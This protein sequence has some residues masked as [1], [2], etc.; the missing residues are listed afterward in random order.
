MR[1]FSRTALLIYLMIHVQSSLYGTSTASK[2][3]LF[4]YLTSLIVEKR[5]VEEE[6]IQAAENIIS[7]VCARCGVASSMGKRTSLEDFYCMSE[8][9]FGV[10]DGHQ[11]QEVAKLT[12]Q[13]LHKKITSHAQYETSPATAIKN[14][15]HSF[16]KE[17]ATQ[18]FARGQSA[19]A[20][21]ALLKKNQLY[22][23]GLG[24]ARTL[25]VTSD[26]AWC[27]VD[28]DIQQRVLKPSGKAEPDIHEIIITPQH[29]FAII[30]TQSIWKHVSNELAILT[31]QDGLKI[32][33]S[34][35]AAASML[36]QTAINHQCED[37]MTAMIIDLKPNIRSSTPTLIPHMVEAHESLLP[38][39]K[40]KSAVEKSKEHEMSLEFKKRLPE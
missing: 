2:L 16:Q 37:N 1:Q 8:P 14:S 27:S 24:D 29:K 30:A 3:S 32:H 23:A 10:Y 26:Y 38:L 28:H 18:Q 5:R 39:Q 22:V 34:L 11:G 9:F 12:A 13:S 36:V 35:E 33:K 6:K 20:A 40:D 4:D 15:F 7:S 31:V 25:V 17:L 21:L 19:S